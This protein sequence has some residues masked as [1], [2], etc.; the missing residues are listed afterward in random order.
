MFVFVRGRHDALRFLTLL[1]SGFT[2][3]LNYSKSK[4]C[5]ELLQCKDLTLL[6]QKYEFLPNGAFY[7]YSI[8]KQNFCIERKLV[9]V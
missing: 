4:K 1:T 8:F 7:Q 3:S 5:F 2:L 6:Q 9:M